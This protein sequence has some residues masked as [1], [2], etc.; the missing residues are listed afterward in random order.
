ML[1]GHQDRALTRRQVAEGQRE[2]WDGATQ[3]F[4]GMAF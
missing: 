1:C 4:E 2:M 3:T